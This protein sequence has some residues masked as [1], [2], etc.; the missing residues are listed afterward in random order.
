MIECKI[1]RSE[2]IIVLEPRGTLAKD[3]FVS[4]SA[5]V[6]SHLADNHR[7]R[8]MLIHSEL[9]PGWGSFAAF[10]AHMRFDQHHERKIDRVAVVTDSF[11][12]GVVE[13]LV[14]H[15]TTAEIKVFPYVDYNKAV[16]WLKTS[17][18]KFHAEAL[19]SGHP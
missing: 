5:T 9:F 16:N 15:F 2:G 17:P 13:F 7:I 12:V 14:L 1:I 10:T 18:N 11:I 6:D 4:L 19:S 8:G 3:D